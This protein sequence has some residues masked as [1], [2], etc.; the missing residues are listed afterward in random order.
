MQAH[1]L[2]ELN[3]ITLNLAAFLKVKNSK[4]RKEDENVSLNLLGHMIELVG[5]MPGKDK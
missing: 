4:Q 5:E 2:R 3:H 1:F